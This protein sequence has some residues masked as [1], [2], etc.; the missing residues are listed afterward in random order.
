MRTNIKTLYAVSA[1]TLLMGC[2]AVAPALTQLAMRFGQDLIAAAS[3]NHAPRYAVELES[4]LVALAQQATGMQ[5]QGQLAQLGYQ[6]PPPEYMQNQ[7]AYNTGGYGG[8]GQSNDP[9]GQANNPY[10]QNNGQYGQANDPY[11]Q[12]NDPY[13]QANDPYGQANNDPYGQANDP[14]GQANNDPYGQANDPYGQADDPYGQ[15]NDPYG[16]AGDPYS[17]S[18]DP[19]AQAEDPYGQNDEPYGESGDPYGET[20]D[21]YG[22]TNGAYA[23]NDPYGGSNDP[24]ASG[25]AAG[26]Q[27]AVR[28]LAPIELDVAI[29]AQR[30]GSGELVAVEDGDTLH[31]GGADPLAGDLLKVH[32][33]ANCRCFVYVIGV[34]A[35]GYVAQIFPDSE[36]GHSNPVQP[37]AG[38]LTPGGENDWWAM[39]SFKGVEQIYFMASYAQ[40]PD[41]EQILEQMAG[42]PR[43][44]EAQNY[45]PVAA[46]AFIPTTRGLVK[47]KSQQPV[48]VP[49]SAAGPQP[50]SATL[51]TNEDPGGD[52]VITRWFNH[53]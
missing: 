21:P 9:Y 46:P 12:A 13:S 16:Q 47:V 2:E 29:L 50:V 22:E 48:A 20:N 45:Q 1:L 17:Q 51:F 37:G 42:M 31:D 33:R 8:Y 38:Y 27:Y 44:P 53:K 10:G 14:Y 6:A 25:E 30:R 35:T 4:L 52:L 32:F 15:A 24:Y 18:D 39:D 23:Q 34:D 3:V 26:V 7:Q 49:G 41:I 40:R 11:G 19:Y 36:E 5:M 43:T 28:G